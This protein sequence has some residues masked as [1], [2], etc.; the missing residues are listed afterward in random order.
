MASLVRYELED[1]IA[2]L[3]LDD[4]RK[5]LVS[6]A[7]LRD[8]HAAL[9]RAEADRAIVVL[10]GAGTTFSAGF[11]LGVMG[12][13]RDQAIAMVR[14][15]FELAERMLAFPLPIVAACNGHAIAMGSFLLLSA[16]YRF[17]VDGPFR[18]VANEVA[19]GLTMPRPAVEL[20]RHR[21][22]PAC[23]QRATVLA[24][25]FAPRDAVAAGFLDRVVAPEDLQREARAFALGLRTLSM[26]AHAASKLRA[27]ASCLAAIRAGIAED[28]DGLAAS[29]AA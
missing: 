3:T 17:G 5:N 14:G 28:F 2:T 1:S 16:D 20:M 6:P 18:L 12:S 11:D 22:T 15:G 25:V 27:R 21:L 8:I 10:T 26:D 29:A 4:G 19:I 23:F 9:N 24:E 7:M 13:D